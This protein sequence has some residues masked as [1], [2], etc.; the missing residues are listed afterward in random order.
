M[1]GD[2][3]HYFDEHPA[4][5]SRESSY[6]FPGPHGPLTVISDS[7]VFS[8]GA[9]DKA[10]ALLLREIASVTVPPDG[11]ILD[12]GC[13]AGPIAF[14]LASQHPDRTVRAVDT[15]SRAVDVC[16]RGARE[17]GLANVVA[18]RPEDV[19]PNATF[20]LMCSNPPIRIGKSELH[21]LLSRWLGRLCPNGVAYLVVGRHLGADS[22]QRWLNDQ[23]W[24]T[25]RIGSSKGFRILR[26]T[27]RA[28]AD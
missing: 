15:N 14:Y 22:L 10:T 8:H 16:S 9:L 24:P 2:G 12:L 5:P 27:P 25:Q 11:D 20:G 6:T 18:S 4:S 23:G 19:P 21:E 28:A 7:G 17:N 13:G 1:N 3:G 26:I